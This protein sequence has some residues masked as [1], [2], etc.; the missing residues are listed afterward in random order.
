MRSLA[1]LLLL[2][3]TASVAVWH[4]DG[5]AAEPVP[6]TESPVPVEGETEAEAEPVVLASSSALPGLSA[7]MGG[8]VV[9][10]GADRG[11]PPT[12]PPKR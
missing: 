9:F 10:A 8:Q 5:W 4:A 12:P 3:C 1:V 2:M 7:R 11:A 6:V